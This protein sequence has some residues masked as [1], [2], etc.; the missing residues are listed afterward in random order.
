MKQAFTLIELLVVI[1]IIALLMG[2][3]LP[4]IGAVQKAANRSVC[5]NNMRQA[6][7]S[8][9][10]Y[11]DENKGFMPDAAAMPSLNLNSKKSLAD[12]LSPY[13]DEPRMLA[14]PMDSQIPYF[15][16]EGSSYTLLGPMVGQKVE[17][18]F[19]TKRFGEPNTPVM[20][21]YEPFHGDAGEQ[22]SMNYLFA[23]GHVADIT[24]IKD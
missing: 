9:R 13:Y 17:N 20:H 21:E 10:M 1:S 7:L 14:C 24:S 19:F 15:F 8:L 6:G 11:A 22:G 4:A 3:L 23:D 16:R 2:L 12:L 18:S 5:Q